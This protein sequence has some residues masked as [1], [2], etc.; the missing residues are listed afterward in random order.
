MNILFKLALGALTLDI[1]KNDIVKGVVSAQRQ[2]QNRAEQH[3][4]IATLS[5]VWMEFYEALVMVN[6]TLGTPEMIIL[7]EEDLQAAKNNIKELRRIGNGLGG[8]EKE[9]LLDLAQLLQ[10]ELLEHEQFFRG[11]LR[12]KFMIG[13]RVL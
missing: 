3:K 12:Q 6:A 2:E 11:G 9:R 4:Q 8:L 7:P 5:K 10:K 1:L 13:G